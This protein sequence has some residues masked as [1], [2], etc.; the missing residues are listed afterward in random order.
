MIHVCQTVH[1]GTERVPACPEC[2]HARH[3]ELMKQRGDLAAAAIVMSQWRV[4]EHSGV[5]RLAHSVDGDGP[6]RNEWSEISWAL[7][8]MRKFVAVLDAERQRNGLRAKL[9]LRE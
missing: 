4:W 8:S 1:V 3:E 6:S 5:S 2:M 9:G 7:E